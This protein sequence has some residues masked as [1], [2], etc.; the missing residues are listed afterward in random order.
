MD[1][2]IGCHRVIR[3]PDDGRVVERH[4]HSMDAKLKSSDECELDEGSK[5]GQHPDGAW[6]EVR[7]RSQSDVTYILSR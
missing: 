3:L 1:A 6:C 7:L 5:V 4:G 2:P